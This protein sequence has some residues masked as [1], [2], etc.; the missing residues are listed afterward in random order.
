[1]GRLHDRAGLLG[2]NSLLQRRRETCLPECARART[3][4]LR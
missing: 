2:A 3:L 4:S 1:V